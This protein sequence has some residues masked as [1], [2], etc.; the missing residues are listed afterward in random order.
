MRAVT[1][2]DVCA[3]GCTYATI[4]EALDDIPNLVPDTVYEITLAAGTYGESLTVNVDAEV[5]ILGAGAGLTSITGNG[6]RVIDFQSAGPA[7]ALVIHD[8]T[9]TGGVTDG[10]GGG[11]Q[12]TGALTLRRVIISGNNTAGRGGAI[13]SDTGSAL[14]IEDSVIT[15]NT[16][17]VVGDGIQANGSLSVLRTLFNNNDIDRQGAATGG[18]T[19]ADSAFVNF[20]GVAIDANAAVTVSSS[21][22]GSPAGPVGRLNGEA[23]S[24][25]HITALTVAPSASPRAVGASVT[26]SV[27]PVL[28]DGAYTGTLAANVLREGPNGGSSVATGTGTATTAYVG[29]AAGED[30][31]TATML[32]AGENGGGAALQ[33]ATAVTWQ[34]SPVA[35]AGGPYNE[36]E[37]TAVQFDASASTS[38]AGGQSY[39]WTF[40]DGG[41]GVGVAPTH[42]YADNGNYTVQVTVTD[43]DGDESAMAEVAITNV[44]PIVNAGS[45]RTVVVGTNNSIT[46][47][48]VDPGTADGPWNYSVNWGD[49]SEASVGAVGSGAPFAV[50]HVFATTGTFDV[51]VCVV[52]KDAAEGCGG[53]AIQVQTPPPPPPP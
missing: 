51:V 8:V 32:W 44:A 3:A 7:S 23:A 15:G 11:I 30:A 52:D 17:A 9:L 5:R 24:T 39:A 45:D 2:L 41:V 43:A 6:A 34:V 13:F 50:N 40:G 14:S 25:S 22:W 18:A 37:G 19:I 35:S 46:P 49:G 12:S 31:V 1:T 20:V 38:L 48:F 53:L 29:G 42:A 27:T 16:A 36:T 47:S 21:W 10:H 33:G 4:T 26:I 28:N